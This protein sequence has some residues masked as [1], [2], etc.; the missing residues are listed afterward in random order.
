MRNLSETSDI[1]GRPV[2][3]DRWG[4]WHRYPPTFLDTWGNWIAFGGTAL[5]IAICWIVTWVLI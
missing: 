1:L 4:H 3:R 2:F 5:A